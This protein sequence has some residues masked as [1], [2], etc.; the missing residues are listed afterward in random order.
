MSS[1]SAQ[2]STSTITSHPNIPMP[3][4]FKPEWLPDEF[5]QSCMLCNENFTLIKRRHHCR[6]CGKIFCSQC[7]N[8]KAKLLY[9][10]NAEERICIHCSLLME[11]MLPRCNEISDPNVTTPTPSTSLGT[12]GSSSRQNASNVQGVLKTRCDKINTSQP[13]SNLSDN[14]TTNMSN[15][16]DTQQL[17][18]RVTFPDG[19]RP[20]ADLSET[21]TK[22]IIANL[23]RR[24]QTS[25]DSQSSVTKLK[26]SRNINKLSTSGK[27]NSLTI[28]DELGFLPPIVR[29]KSKDKSVRPDLRALLGNPQDNSLKH[30][31]FREIAEVFSD[32]LSLTFILL[33]G[34]NLKAKIIHLKNRSYNNCQKE[35]K[36]G[37][38]EIEDEGVKSPIECWCFVSE[39]LRKLEQR[40]LLFVLSKEPSEKCIPRDVFQ[41][42]LMM[43]ELAL[44]GQS[45]HNLGSLVFEHGLF[46]DK[47]LNGVLF[48]EPTHL[49]YLDDVITAPQNSFLV[50]ML[51]RRSEIPWAKIFPMRLY[52]GFGYKFGIYSSTFINYRKRDPLYYEVGHSIISILG[53]FRNYRYSVTHIEGMKV[54]Y[55]KDIG[56]VYVSFPKSS[57]KQVNTVLD[58]SSNEHVLAWS[59]AFVADAHGHLVALQ[60]ED[61]E[62]D[63]VEFTKSGEPKSLVA[64]LDGYQTASNVDS[65]DTNPGIERLIGVSFIIFSGALKAVQTNQTAKIGIVEDGLLVQIQACTMTALKNSIKYMDNFDICCGKYYY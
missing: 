56:K 39:G 5:T 24:Q 9:L 55:S 37:K 65:L 49:Q 62:Y 15:S 33:K 8:I 61:G 2:P 50:C 43:H 26:I 21:S 12:T 63:S 47:T 60:K 42:Y 46:D 35:N 40:E 38:D 11:I 6:S 10:N 34:F 20:G 29:T 1:N 41:I 13:S 4:T 17:P 3:G 22:T 48:V 44:R 59:S 7:C 25:T 18:K 30:I 19:I 31:G 28:F 53:D 58:N 16:S 52:Y 36:P 51:L 54:R 45:L 57:Y 64:Q 23:P 32:D 27:H 14:E